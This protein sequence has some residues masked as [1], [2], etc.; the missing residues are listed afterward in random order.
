MNRLLRALVWLITAPFRLIFWLIICLPLRFLGW[1]FRPF[2]EKF[3]QN[4]VY[5]FMTEVPEDR[6]TLDVL[7]DAVQDPMQLL[8][9]LEEV[10]KH[11]LRAVAVLILTTG[12]S[13][14]Y[15]QPLIAF[16]AAPVGGLGNL[17]A[18]NLTDSVG[19][20]MMV[21]FISGISLALP[22]MAFEAW[23]F[24]APGLMPRARQLGLIAIPLALFFF[25]SGAAFTYWVMLSPAVNFLLTILP[26]K[27]ITSVTS[28]VTIVSSLIFWVGISF[29]FPLVIWALS[30]MGLVRYQVLLEHWRIAIVAIA[31]FAAVITPTVD[32]VNQGLVMAPMIIL[33]FVSILFSYLA[34]PT[35]ANLS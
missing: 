9:E 10:R 28:Y 17:Y 23:L 11:L 4:S 2:A 18:P 20:F 33:Y 29:E 15:V 34:R 16:L 30:A 14:F 3:K 26:I 19:V 32:P 12:V 35:A 25:L 8:G 13:F 21:A 22:Y 1:L 24:I 6:P 27:Q 7:A 5:R 31:I